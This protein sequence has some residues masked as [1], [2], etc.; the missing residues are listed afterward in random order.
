MDPELTRLAEKYVWWETPERALERQSL[1]LCQLLQL[2]TWTDVQLVRARL[3]D[4][5]LRTALQMAPP[6][7]LDAKSWNYWHLYYHL[8]PVP[9]MPARPLP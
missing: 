6:G 1:F 8:E 7:I 5:A 9:P 2:G 3:G 4:A